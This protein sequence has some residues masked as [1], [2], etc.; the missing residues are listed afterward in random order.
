MSTL[1]QIMNEGKFLQLLKYFSGPEYLDTITAGQDEIKLFDQFGVSPDCL[2]YMYGLLSDLVNL[3]NNKS[4]MK[5]MTTNLVLSN[6]IVED[7]KTL[8]SKYLIK[9]QSSLSKSTLLN[10]LSFAVKD[11]YNFKSYADIAE[12]VL[13]DKK[14]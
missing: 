9:P 11:E 14:K 7:E 5:N 12:D 10:K 3:Y 13:K 4:E 2:N 8:I 1:A 6:T